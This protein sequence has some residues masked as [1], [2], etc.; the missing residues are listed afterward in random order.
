ML[1]T[2]ESSLSSFMALT[3]FHRGRGFRFEA[4]R[5]TPRSVTKK[6]VRVRPFF[7]PCPAKPPHKAGISYSGFRPAALVTGNSR[8]SRHDT[9]PIPTYLVGPCWRAHSPRSC[10]VHCCV[11]PPQSS[12][13]LIR[14]ASQ[15]ASF[16]ESSCPQAGH[17]PAQ[18]FVTGAAI[19]VA[20]Q[21]GLAKTGFLHLNCCIISP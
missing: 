10:G 21:F 16:P 15:T 14:S 7:P 9:A 3:S 12:A 4:C 8:H 20:G 6:R 13:G 5:T 1:L 18:I 17:T 19:I 2:E 11:Q